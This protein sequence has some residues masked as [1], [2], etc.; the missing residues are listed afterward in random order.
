MSAVASMMVLTGALS[1]GGEA[2][3]G[4]TTVGDYTLHTFTRGYDDN[5]YH[6]WPLEA[7][8][9]AGATASAGNLWG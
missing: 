8:V 3:G 1:G 4:V 2:T 6:L 9:A 5:I 7:A